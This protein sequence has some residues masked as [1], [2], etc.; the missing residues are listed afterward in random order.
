MELVL[1]PS[2]NLKPLPEPTTL[3]FGRYFSDHMFNMEFKEELGWI[4]PRIEEY[5]PFTLDPSTLVFHYSQTIFEGMKAYRT[6][7]NRIQLFRPMDNF[8]RMNKSA[9]SLC[10]P[11]FDSGFVLNAL[12]ELLKTDQKWVPGLE[13]TSLY[14]RPT[15]IATENTL[16]VKVSNEYKFFII[17]SPVSSYYVEGFNPIKIWV[18]P[19]YVRAVPGGVGEV[20]TGGNYAASLY[21]GELA[22]KK[23]FSQVLW[24]DG[25]EHRYIE[26][27]GSMNIFFVINDEIITPKLVGSI[28]PGITRDSVLKLTKSWGMK[29]FER[30]ISLEEVVKSVQDGSLT[31][32]FG[33]GTAAAISPVGEFCV[34]NE[35]Y[36]V[37]K[38]LLGPVSNRLFQTLTDIQYGRTTDSFNWIEPV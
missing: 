26:E 28:L 7:E 35:S 18:S 12:K 22:H 19:Q 17:L 13:G 3:G 30:Q 20:K 33:S 1:T 6:K 29:V 36:K 32:M 37:N 5:Q 2:K 31:E 16:G 10:M 38:G 27:V 8:I 15:M 9:R 14:I 34:E 23:G 4:N 11:E 21:A 25:I 24:L